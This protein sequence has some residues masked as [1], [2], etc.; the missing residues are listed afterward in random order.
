MASSSLMGN[1]GR[2]SRLAGFGNIGA[3]MSGF[4][5]IVGW[6]GRPPIGPFGPYTDYVAPRLALVVLLAALDARERSGRGCYLD[7]SQAECGVWFLSP[8][9]AAFS[10]DGTMPHGRGNRD[11]VFVP[12]GVFPCRAD[13]PGRAEHVAIAVRDDRDWQAVTA[14]MGRRELALDPLYATAEG[15]RVHEDRLEAMVGEWTATRTA[16][17]IEQACQAAA[18]PAHRAST[19]TD[20]VTDPQMAHRGHLIRL[21]HRLH[22]EVVVE[23]PRY[24]LSDTPGRVVKAAPTIG[25]DNERVLAGILG[26]EPERIKALEDI[27]ALR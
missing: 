13:G 26:W 16:S 21:P 5:A 20:F 2:Y 22:G 10:A 15:R 18:V 4:Q 8:Q 9:V 24:L 23:G 17:E 3:A 14:I 11:A 19:S 6:P 12:H 25:E 1:M 7:V 27:G